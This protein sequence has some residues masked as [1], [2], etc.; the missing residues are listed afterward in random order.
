MA[1]DTDT[2]PKK[3]SIHDLGLSNDALEGAEFDQIPE[4]LGQSFPD[5]PQPGKYRFKAAS[6]LTGQIAP[7]KTEKYG[8]RINLIF[9]QDAPLTII[10][11][12]AKASDGEEFYYRISNVPRERTKEHILISDMDI[13]L[14][15]LGVSKKPTGNVDYAKAAIGALAGKEFG[16]TVEFSYRCS[17]QREAY[18]DDGQGGQQRVEGRMGCGSRW[19]QR[20]VPKVDGQQPVRIT[21]TNPDCGASV[22]AFPNLT[23]FT[24]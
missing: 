14:R 12:P 21:C 2:R 1:N 3:G 16:A 7:V 20:D 15:A 4:N 6:N 5:P 22:R 9:D 19:Y 23:G 11:S 8:T 17:D 18:F 24:K 13:L 10:Q